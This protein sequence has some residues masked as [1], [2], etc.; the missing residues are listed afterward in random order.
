MKNDLG[1]VPSY[2]ITDEL[3]LSL[4]QRYETQARIN[5]R[6]NGLA[7]R[8]LGVEEGKEAVEAHPTPEGTIPNIQLLI[9]DLARLQEQTEAAIVALE[10]L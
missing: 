6:L 1:T 3:H 4:L 9:S 2:S 10:N 8:I 5:A 7:Y